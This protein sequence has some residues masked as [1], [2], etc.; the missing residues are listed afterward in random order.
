METTT[1]DLFYRFGTAL[2]IGLLIGLQR[3]YASYRED[4]KPDGH[5]EDDLFAGARTFALLSLLGCAGAFASELLGA[6]WVFAGLLLVTGALITAA[7]VLESREGDLGL[8]TE[9]AAL[10]TLVVGALCYWDYLE[11]AAALAVTITVLLA[12]KLQTRSLVRRLSREDVYATLKFAVISLVVLPVLPREGYGPPPF[13]V[14][15]PYE[16]WL[17]V[18]FISGISFL[19]YLLIQ[20]VGPRRGVGL[21]GLLGGLASSTAVTL[22]FA[23]RSHDAASLAKSFALAILVAWSVMFGRV[24][25]EVAALNLPL[26]GVVWLPVVAALAVSLAYCAYLYLTQTHQADE[27]ADDFTNPFELGP[28]LTFGLLYAV[29]LL[30]ANAAKLYLG[31]TGV[32]LSS[33]ASGLADVDAITLSMAQLSQPGSSSG[34]AIDLRTA[35]RAIVL[36]A[37][38]NTVVK[39]GIVL[40]LGSA[41]L[42]K[43]ILPGLVL[44]LATAIGVVFLL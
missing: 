18:V 23:Q 29:I 33:I 42:R 35:A 22:T 6:F 12:L 36:A 32:Y 24:L 43:A 41:A 28:A 8:T 38:S 21:T 17:M 37:A 20:I 39:G 44:T 26:L 25:V 19:G 9:V 15:V 16:V 14:V 40:S 30:V 34:E 11:V 4:T 10:L 2:A 5:A 31:D 13:D 3:E 1:L 27:P 7:Y